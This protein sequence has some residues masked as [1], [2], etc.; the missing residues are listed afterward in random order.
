MITVVVGVIGRPHGVR[1]EVA[2]ELRTDEP[3][4]RFAPG[5]VLREEGGIRVLTVK[6]VRDQSGR[7]LVRFA[8]LVDRA[9]A[10]AA[11]GTILLAAIEANERPD[12]PETFYDRQL[13]G[14]R[15]TTP[16]GVEVGTVG[17]ILHL[18]A[19][20]VLEI[21]TTSGT[22][23]VPFVAAL[24]PEVDLDAGR[25]TVVDLEGLLDDRDD[26]DED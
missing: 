18:P 14:L 10:E 24:V 23:L 9:A 26:A 1:G 13:I 7:L 6:S 16:H 4:R 22:R 2:I 17:S 19:Q 12:E 8:E 20:E 3:E 25:L 11:R 15:V 5:Q 21:E